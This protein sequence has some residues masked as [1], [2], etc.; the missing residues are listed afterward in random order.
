MMKIIGI[1]GGM[2]AASTQIYYRELCALTRPCLG[3]L[4][5]SELLIRSLDF[6]TIEAL[7]VN[8]DW[9]AA[10]A[11]LNHEAKALE[12]PQ[13]LPSTFRTASASGT[14]VFSGSMAGLCTPDASPA[15]SQ[16]PAHGWGPMQFATPS[17]WRTFTTYSLP[18]SLRTPKYIRKRTRGT[19][20]RPRTALCQLRP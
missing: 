3:G 18:V 16:V 13:I 17:S 5:S 8:G 11:T 15:R 9:D 4:H 2:S 19:R 14:N 7:Q 6:A 20:N 10:G 12:C 1:L